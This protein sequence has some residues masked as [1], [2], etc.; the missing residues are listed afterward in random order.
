[1]ISKQLDNALKALKRLSR[2]SAKGIPLHEPYFDEAENR[3][4]MDCISSTFVSSVGKYVD[5]FEDDLASFVDAKHSVA[6]VNGT[7]A[8]HVALLLIG[9]GAGDE[10]IVPTLSFV[11]T[12]NA[13]S[14]CNAIPHFVDSEEGS[15]GIDPLALRNWLMKSTFQRNGACINKL[16]GRHIKALIVM[17]VFGHP[18]DLE[19]LLL[20]SKDFSLILVEDAAE[21]LGSYYK[22]KHVGTFGDISAFSFNGNKIITTGG[23]GAIVT[24]NSSLASS[25]KHLTTTAKLPHKWNYVHNRIGFNYRMPNINAAIGCAQLEKIEN[26]LKLKR[27]L[28]HK[29]EEIFSGVHEV[30]LIREPSYASSNYWLQAIKLKSDDQVVLEKILEMTNSNGIM[31]RPIWNLLHTLE[32]YQAC[33]RAPLPTA[34]S[35]R[36]RVIN[37]P[38]S[39]ILG[40]G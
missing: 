37:L 38:S 34:I 2:D 9:V 7:S 39:S 22:G 12:A 14:Y 29:Y 33:P 17:H 13:V 40:E 35:L 26:L 6:V 28:F 8:L 36:G 15:M 19:E 27:N 30:D 4:L 16:T 3:F 11:A 21:G 31:T 1:M 18:C 20:V 5:Q 25:A 23:G 24:N 10:V 32:P